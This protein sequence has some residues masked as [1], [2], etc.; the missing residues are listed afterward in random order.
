MP[1][2]S[3]MELLRDYARHGS[4]AAF[5]ELVRRHVNLVYSAAL[6][7]VGIAA[8][9]EEIAQAV[10]VIL[11]RKAARLRP[12]T[13]LEAWFY[14][15]TRLTSL[16]FLRGERRRHWREQEACMQTAL[17]ESGE[18]PI[19][20]QLAPLLDEAMARLGKTD[21]EAVV[22][23]Y[24]KG[25]SLNE[26][27]AAL[28]TTE[29][30]AQSRVHRAVGK[31]QNYFL[32][33]GIDSTTAAIAGAISANSI[34]AAPLALAKT[35]TAVALAKGA[36]ASTS[37]L[38]LIK[39]ALKIMAWTKVKTAVVVGAVILLAGGTTFVVVKKAP[40]SSG[41]SW[42]VF[43]PAHAG[44]FLSNAPPKATIVRRL[45]KG[46]PPNDLASAGLILSNTPPQVT[47]VP[48]RFPKGGMLNGVRNWGWMYTL[49]NGEVIGMN[50]SAEEIIRYAMSDYPPARTM[51]EGKLPERG[52]KVAERGY[53]F[54]ANLPNGSKAALKAEVERKFG[55]TE[56]IENRQTD[57]LILRV[58]SAIAR[59][60]LQ[61]TKVAGEGGSGL[62][63]VSTSQLASEIE[64]LVNVPVVDETGL[65]NHFK[66]TL[67]WGEGDKLTGVEQFNRS[68]DKIGLELVPARRSIEMLV[69]EK[70]K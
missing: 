42:Q 54:I 61:G 47:I 31:L 55:L 3:D 24:F 68:L 2:V 37:T 43:D 25:K 26:V 33:R 21:R 13:I 45:P 36:A 34:Q 10:F 44:L 6:R 63:V 60:Y 64:P 22:L 32:Q 7:H 62:R 35:V 5:A 12:D 51:V 52:P 9:A 8:H 38:T 14:Q 4:E 65:T 41:Y 20:N 67:K 17:Q 69:V 46:V 40:D 28:K 15:T 11:A 58:K 53:D 1:D 16:S 18:P 39:G 59:D 30:A 48:S 57:V 56:R 70:A 66:L 29:A 50:C 49:R 27:A 19:W 23:R